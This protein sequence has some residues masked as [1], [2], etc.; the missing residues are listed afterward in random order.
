MIEYLSG[1]PEIYDKH[2]FLRLLEITDFTSAD[3]NLRSFL[4]SSIIAKDGECLVRSELLAIFDKGDAASKSRAA[5]KLLGSG[6]HYNTFITILEQGDEE[7]RKKA[8]EALLDSCE[9]EK[10]KS[11][12]SIIFE[13]LNDEGEKYSGVLNRAAMMFYNDSAMWKNA[14]P[15]KQA[16]ILSS[17]DKG[18]RNKVAKDIFS[19]IKKVLK[20]ERCH[21]LQICSMLL[22]AE[23]D[24]QKFVEVLCRELSNLPNCE[25]EHGEK[26]ENCVALIL[27]YLGVARFTEKQDLLDWSM[28]QLLEN[29][30]VHW[31]RLKEILEKQRNRLSE[32]QIS[33]LE[34]KIK[35]QE[36]KAKW[37]ESKSKIES[38][39]E[40]F[41]RNNFGD[42]A[43]NDA[44]N[45]ILS[46]LI[47]RGEHLPFGGRNRGISIIPVGGL[48]DIPPE[49]LGSLPPELVEILGG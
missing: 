42:E 11:V 40:G 14:E 16:L 44:K 21:Q 6:Y 7:S 10:D 39:I 27:F 28:T 23:L 9:K 31:E 18:I 29:E 8:A 20:D 41:F 17:L 25:E 32:D 26:N 36:A 19:R 47:G 3:E 46:R 49:L 22:Q 2:L 38:L 4:A 48:E 24:D 45:A 5:E 13:H 33:N 12:I 43:M 34:N 37:A 1:K 15:Q 35:V 30:A